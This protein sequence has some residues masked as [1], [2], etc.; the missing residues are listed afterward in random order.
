MNCFKTEN[1]ND[2]GNKAMKRILLLTTG[3]TI[4]SVKTENGLAPGTSGEEILSYIPEAERYCEIQVK[5]ILSLDS[6]NLQPEHWLRMAG[7][8]R[9]EYEHYDGFVITHGTDTMAYTAAALSYLIQNAD[10]PVILTGAQKPISAAITDARKNLLDSIRFAVKEGVCG[11][12]IVF[13]GK[14]ILGTRARKVRTKSYSAFDS[15]NYPVAAFIDDKRILQYVE[16]EEDR[17]EVCFYDRIDP[18]VFLLKLIPGMEPEILRYIGSRY[19]AIIIESYGV[20]GIPFYDRRNFLEELARLT[21]AGKIVVIATQVMLEGSDAEVY[22]VG[23]KAVNE[24]NV[25]Q[26]Y[27]MTVEAAAV[28]LMWILGRTREFSR[29][30]ELFYR[31]VSHDIVSTEA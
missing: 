11:V 1:M 13:D 27:D 24:Y 28:K 12:Y 26:A 23:F 5:Q 30:Q 4:A 16:A 25:L 15:I 14:A 22:E 9:K 18:R 10:K 31:P 29:V 21:E 3:G 17:G 6:T 20:G 8:I 7:E 2:E 19:D